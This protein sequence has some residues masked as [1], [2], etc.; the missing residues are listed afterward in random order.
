MS[1]KVFLRNEQ[2]VERKVVEL[3]RRLNVRIQE[4]I[5]KYIPKEA[6]DTFELSPAQKRRITN[7]IQHAMLAYAK[8][9]EALL[10]RGIEM[11]AVV[12]LQAEQNSL[13]RHLGPYYEK[14]KPLLEELGERMLRDG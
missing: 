13:R 6:N 7:E 14:A 8:Q 3:N 12:A 2:L 9:L 10:R 4:I 11:A 1:R 5:N